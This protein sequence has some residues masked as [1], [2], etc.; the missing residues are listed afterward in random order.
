MEALAEI[1]AGTGLADWMRNGRW[2]YAAVSG[3]H[4]LGIALLIGAIASLDLR[5]IGLWPMIPVEPLGRVLVPVAITGLA[6]AM[7]AGVLLFLAA[8]GDYLRMRL[9]LLKLMLIALGAG[10]ALWFHA[11]KGFER[12]PAALRRVG[13]TSLVIWLGVLACGRM[14]AFVD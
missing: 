2:I 10:H 14:L 8:P 6:L 9:F 3:L 4:V 12:P 13:L 5:L 7:G 11:G 1:L